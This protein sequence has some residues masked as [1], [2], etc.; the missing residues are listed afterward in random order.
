[1]SF[2]SLEKA[3]DLTPANLKKLESLVSKKNTVLLNHADWCGHCQVFKPQWEEFR[4]KVGK[5]VNVV[6]IENG[7]LTE[8]QRNKTLYKK[9]TPQDGLVYY[10]MIIVF[11]KKDSKPNSEKK[12]YDGNRTATDLKAYVDS[13]VQ[14]KAKVVASR[15]ALP[16]KRVTTNPVKNTLSL[17]DLNN[18]FESILKQMKHSM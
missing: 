7:A 10:P 15:K 14:K 4:K 8:L 5:G 9:I 3:Q 11:V 6:Q 17:F 1:M 2:L 18:E 13:K 12:I 16:S